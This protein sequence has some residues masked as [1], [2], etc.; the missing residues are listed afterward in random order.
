MNAITKEAVSVEIN[1]MLI[2][3]LGM[4]LDL[5]KAI[6]EEADFIKDRLKD[7]ATKP[8]GQTRFEGT[9][10]K[11]QVVCSNPKKTDWDAIAKELN[12]PAE[13]IAKHTTTSAKFDV[14][15]AK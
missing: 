13:I 1:E 10:F 14:R 3:M 11:F 8:N 7:E 2:D 15:T 12:I 6:K 9:F 4:K 5:I